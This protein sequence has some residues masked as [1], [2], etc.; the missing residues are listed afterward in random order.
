MKYIAII[1]LVVLSCS[2]CQGQLFKEFFKQ[3]QTQKEYLL[4]QIAAFRTYSGHVKKGYSI[5]KKGLTNIRNIKNRDLEMHSKFFA[6]L[7]KVNTKIYSYSKV[8]DI[9][10]L[11]MQIVDTY[12]STYNN[13]QLSKMFGSREMR[14][15]YKVFSNLLN[16]CAGDIK[17]LN[18]LTTANIF[19]MKD[20]ERIQR[21]EAIYNN[22]KDQFTFARS[23]DAEVKIMALQRM[24]EKHNIQ[25][26]RTL[27]GVKKK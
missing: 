26:S 4:K 18:A 12:K 20:D 11:E 21:I 23:F 22:V 2:I 27:T 10:S 6:S 13:A 19:E 5:A 9:I 17:E 15:I 7:K 8:A 14:Y 1:F 25:S 16:S 24:K 3:E